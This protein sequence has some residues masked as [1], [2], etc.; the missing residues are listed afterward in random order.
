MSAKTLNVGALLAGLL[1]TSLIAAAVALALPAPV[2]AAGIQPQLECFGVCPSC[3]PCCVL[4]WPI[5]VCD[6]YCE[7]PGGSWTCRSGYYCSSWCPY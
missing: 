6:E 7:M 2:L 5:R 1:I 3:G 4:Q